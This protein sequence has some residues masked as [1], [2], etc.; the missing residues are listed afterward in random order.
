VI[1][2]ALRV[3]RAKAMKF[4]ILPATDLFRKPYH[5]SFIDSAVRYRAVA[6]QAREIASPLYQFCPSK[7]VPGWF[8]SSPKE[9]TKSH[10]Y[11]SARDI[12]QLNLLAPNRLSSLHAST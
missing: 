3:A 5:R 10:T 7:F 8:R 4:M 6:G 9:V 2:S 12:V 11:A 1:V